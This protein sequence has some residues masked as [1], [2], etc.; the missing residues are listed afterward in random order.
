[1][2]SAGT[3]RLPQVSVLTLGGTIASTENGRGAVPSIDGGDLVAAVP[4]LAR[5]A[6]LFVVPQGLIPPCDVD[7]ERCIALAGTVAAAAAE[8]ADGVVITHGTDTLEE[9]AHGSTYCATSGAPSC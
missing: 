3:S 7:I 6:A 4:D 1:M 5:L 9:T 8:G 2:T